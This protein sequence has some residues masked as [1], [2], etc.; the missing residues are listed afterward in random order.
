MFGLPHSPDLPVS[1]IFFKFSV[2]FGVEERTLL[3]FSDKFIQWEL[4]KMH[5]RH[6]FLEEYNVSLGMMNKVKFYIN[7]AIFA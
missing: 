4:L 1:K 5:L 7:L 2:V 6:T 3:N